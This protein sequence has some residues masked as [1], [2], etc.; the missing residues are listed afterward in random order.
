LHCPRFYNIADLV[1]EDCRFINT[2]LDAN[3]CAI[4]AKNSS[5]IG[6]VNGSTIGD[7]G[8]VLL[9]HTISIFDHCTFVNNSAY[10]NDTWH[11]GSGGALSIVNSTVTLIEPIIEHNLAAY[12]GGVCVMNGDLSIY[13]D[14]LVLNEA[15]VA[16]VSQTLKLGGVG[17]CHG[18]Y[19]P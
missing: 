2:E 13:G 3:N 11:G 18:Y 12:G 19:P 10:R 4:I 14:R 15:R 1:I 7:G 5:F 16:N 6:T 8:A 17:G 9:S